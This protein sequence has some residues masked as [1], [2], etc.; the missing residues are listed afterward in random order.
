MN[1]VI[2][3]LGKLQEKILKHIIKCK[4]L[5]RVYIPYIPPETVSHIAESLC[6]SQPAIFKSVKILIKHHYLD[7]VKY[8]YRYY[9]TPNLQE[10]SK[11]GGVKHLFVT[12]K[13]A[14]A[15]IIYGVSIEKVEKYLKYVISDRFYPHARPLEDGF[16]ITGS[17]ITDYKIDY[18]KHPVDLA[19]KAKLYEL[20]AI[21]LTYVR[22]ITE[23]HT[24]LDFFIKEAMRY[25][26]VNNYFE[27]GYAA[28]RLTADQIEKLQ[29][30]IA[31]KHVDSM[32]HVSTLKE[33]VNKYDIDKDL[34]KKHLRRQREY[35]NLAIKELE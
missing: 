25:A 32:G 23:P 19:E 22:R 12:A 29:L 4:R 14:A 31:L 28:K 35:I 27:D 17:S 1:D 6:Y 13:G 26:L 18:L 21:V 34:L 11:T 20:T 24:K 15:A 7:S 10:S 9:G 33:F 5:K 3:Q 8:E 16:S 2:G 30:F